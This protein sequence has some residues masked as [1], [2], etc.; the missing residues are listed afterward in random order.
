MTVDSGILGGA[1]D[2]DKIPTT[3]GHASIGHRL[4][5]ICAHLSNR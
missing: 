3:S 1:E 5:F 2:R 4:I